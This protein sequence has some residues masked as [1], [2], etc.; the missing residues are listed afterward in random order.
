M[1]DS[2]GADYPSQDIEQPGSADPNAKLV[3]G[4]FPRLVD[5]RKPDGVGSF[6]PGLHRPQDQ[7]QRKNIVKRPPDKGP[8]KVRRHMVSGKDVRMAVDDG[9]VGFRLLFHGLGFDFSWG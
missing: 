8:G 9:L 4:P 5:R 3:P 2:Q 7:R 6:V 1:N